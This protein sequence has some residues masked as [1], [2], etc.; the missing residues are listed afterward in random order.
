MSTRVSIRK[1]LFIGMTAAAC[2]S[3]VGIPAQQAQEGTRPVFADAARNREL[4][5]RST[6]HASAEDCFFP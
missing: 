3:L 4:Y 2:I 6:R 5:I 1:R